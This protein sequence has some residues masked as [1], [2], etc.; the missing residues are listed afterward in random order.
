MT[1]LSECDVRVAAFLLQFL[2]KPVVDS[3]PRV[4]AEAG[5]Q[6]GEQTAV[7]TLVVCTGVDAVSVISHQHT[8]GIHRTPVHVT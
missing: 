3:V 5:Q 1:H 2:P 8:C 4:P 7:A 6:V